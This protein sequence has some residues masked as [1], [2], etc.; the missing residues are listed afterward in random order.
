MAESHSII[1]QRS[2]ESGQVLADRKVASVTPIYRKGI[3]EEPRELQTVSLTLVPGKIV[4]IILGTVA[5]S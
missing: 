4:K 2:G 3:R 5:R 1:Y